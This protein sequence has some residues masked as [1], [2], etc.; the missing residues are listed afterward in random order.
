MIPTISISWFVHKS[1]VW[2]LQTIWV[3]RLPAQRWVQHLIKR[4][5][6]LIVMLLIAVN[7]DECSQTTL[8]VNGPITESF[9]LVN[10][11][12]HVN[13]LVLAVFQITDIV[14]VRCHILT[15]I[16][17]LFYFVP[18]F[19]VFDLLIISCCHLVSGCATITYASWGVVSSW[20]SFS[21][22]RLRWTSWNLTAVATIRLRV[23]FAAFIIWRA[24]FWI[25]NLI[26]CLFNVLFFFK[27]WPH[28]ISWYVFLT[29]A[30][31]QSLNQFLLRRA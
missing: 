20:M 29:W 27:F 15:E 25:L 3:A 5:N 14:G 21:I 30:S 26:T 4:I 13:R 12:Y 1:F 24:W 9:V 19:I 16:I 17:N 6:I 28:R 23:R 18:V 7:L 2:D 31:R 10:L 22:G 11:I 8:L